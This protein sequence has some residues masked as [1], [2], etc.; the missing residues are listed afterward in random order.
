MAAMRGPAGIGSEL[1]E[2]LVRAGRYLRRGV[3]SADVRTLQKSGGREADSFY[4]NRWSYDKV[5]RSTH[6]VNCTGS[7]SWKVYVKD[8]II[9]WEA[10]QTDYPSAGPD[11]PDYEPRGCPRGAAFS[12]YTYSPTRVRYPY[13][14]GVLL[15]LF[16]EAKA[17]HDGDPVEAW[18]EI[19]GNPGLAGRYKSARGK[20]GFVRASWDEAVELAAA[21][22][23]HTIRTWG[24][25][26]IAGFSPIPAMSMVGHAAGAR[27]HAL[28]GAPMLSFYDWY[29]DLPVASPQVFG[30][31]TDV[32][33]SGD[34][35][36]AS[37]LVLWGSNAARRSG[38]LITT[39]GRMVSTM[40]TGAAGGQARSLSRTATAIRDL[41]P[42][43]FAFVM[44]TGIISTGTFLLGPSWLSKGLLVV[45]S[46]GLVVLST[47]L[48]VRLAVFRSSVAADI[49]APERVF[50]FFT[51]VAGIDVLGVRLGAAGH[52]LATAI[53]AG[54]AAALWLA[55]TYGVPASLLL[56]RE[57]DS[58][59]GGVNGTW[60]LW[61]VGTQSLSVAASALIP[62]WPSQSGL[63]APAAVGLWSVGLVLY[64]LLVALILLRWL[65]VAMTPATLG[66]PYWILMG[67][68]AITVLAGAR[69]LN[70]PALPV[71]RATAGFV[72]GFSFTLWAFG[73]WWIPLLIVLGLWRHVRRHWPFSYEPTLWSVVF[74]LGMYS[75]ATL[76]FGKVAHLRFME[77]LSRFML[78]VA[79]AAW[80]VVAA[81]FLVRLARRSG[82]PASGAAAASASA[83]TTAT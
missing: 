46:I 18:A 12:W 6:G 47:A 35:W 70:L 74:P 72:E 11:R 79:V 25:D 62:V 15:E 7:C 51:I 81:A 20:G 83:T 75:V 48:V 38:R 29:A 64:L 55:L 8:G 58:V 67:A 14:R 71:T 56:T 39:M 16:R 27:F 3:V 68:T 49:Q 45:A 43:Y 21:A 54:L 52:P 50:G 5:V 1:D 69:I 36:D 59:L 65:T 42:G 10:Q 78:W 77:P 41:H 60:L 17:R 22:H 61:V 73:T 26:R 28:I 53:L 23:V 37:Y 31:Q 66:P 63:L 24:P 57:R 9:T 34:W 76:S 40:S 82:E 4:R 19:T 2:A 33:E 13:V 32:P 80:V 44:A 30:D